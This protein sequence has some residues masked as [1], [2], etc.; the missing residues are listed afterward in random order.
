[1]AINGK[2]RDVTELLLLKSAGVESDCLST[3]RLLS[4]FSF[5]TEG[6]SRL[7]EFKHF[8]IN[9][10]EGPDVVGQIYQFVRRAGYPV[11]S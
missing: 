4:A 10:Q 5:K 8:V 9:Y 6:G 11:Q 7:L 3:F 1:M 2:K